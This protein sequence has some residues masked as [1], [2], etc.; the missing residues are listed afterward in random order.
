MTSLQFLQMEKGIRNIMEQ[1][2]ANKFDNLDEMDKFFET[3]IT[4]D[5]L[6]QVTYK[7]PI[8]IKEIEFIV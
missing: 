5:H 6:K 3:Q 7:S 2:L 1:F 4:K 8:S